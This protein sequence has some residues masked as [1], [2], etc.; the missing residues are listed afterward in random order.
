LQ[1]SDA[2]TKERAGFARARFA[3]SAVL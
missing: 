3:R 1:Q 2:P